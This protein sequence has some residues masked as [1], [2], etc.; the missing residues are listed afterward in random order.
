[1]SKHENRSKIEI[2]AGV[3]L[4]KVLPNGT[5]VYLILKGNNTYDSIGKWGFPKGH[6][7]LEDKNDPIK[8]ARR[9]TWEETRIE[10]AEE[11]INPEN[12]F[13]CDHDTIIF[14]NV[15][16]K[17]NA[18]HIKMP[19]ELRVVDPEEI[20]RIKWATMEEIIRIPE[21]DKNSPMRQWLAKNYPVRK[22]QK[23]VKQT[24]REWRIN[25]ISWR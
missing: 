16:L 23:P 14:Y 15:D 20:V 24:T 7:E 10:I 11:A 5:S 22:W 19:D 25:N 1:M 8:T 6:M 2:R 18:A 21:K 4:S 9:E 17:E 12:T 3:I 13:K